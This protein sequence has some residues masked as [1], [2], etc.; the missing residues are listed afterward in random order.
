MLSRYIASAADPRNAASAS[1]GSSVRTSASSESQRM[2]SHSIVRAAAASSASSRTHAAGHVRSLAV[3]LPDR[4]A[5]LRAQRANLQRFVNDNADDFA[6]MPFHPWTC[7]T[8]GSRR[9]HLAHTRVAASTL[10]GCVGLQG[11]MLE[12]DVP[13][14]HKQHQLLLYPGLLMTEELYTEFSRSYHCPTALDLPALK[15]HPANKSRA[16]ILI[17]GDPTSHG[18]IINDGVKSGCEGRST[19]LAAGSCADKS[20][21][22]YGCLCVFVAMQPTALFALSKQ[23]N[24]RRSALSA[25]MAS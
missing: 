18:A 13:A 20:C 15:N 2:S 21:V 5:A 23:P 1:A 16:S 17:V 24:S 19:A 8:P 6:A 10:P 4:N 11:V 7:E 22:A 14:R 3:G 12:T 25:L 9:S